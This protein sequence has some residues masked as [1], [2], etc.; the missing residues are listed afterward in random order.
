MK[1]PV[2]KIKVKDRIRKEQGNIEE[3]AKNIKENNLINP[4]VITPDNELIAGARRLKACKLLG[5]DEIEVKIMDITDYEDK[6]MIE[7]SENELRKDFTFSEKLEWAEKIERIERIKAE[8]R[9]KANLKQNQNTDVQNFARR[10][11]KKTREKV[12]EKV[13]LGSGE[14][15]RKAKY[16]AN[17]ADKELINKL[18]KEQISIHGAYQNLKEEKEKL[19]EENQSLK[20]AKESLENEIDE[21][22]KKEIEGLQEEL[23]KKEKLANNLQS[24]LASVSRSEMKISTQKINDRCKE[25]TTENSRALQEIKHLIG[26]KDINQSEVINILERWQI[27]LREIEDDIENIIT[28][29]S[30]EVVIDVK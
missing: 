16:I 4:I 5:W 15:Y 19:A 11:N 13:G 20:N 6:L 9:S 28:N 26:E 2:K 14:T 29:I 18:D 17:N 22:K 24:E 8:E 21:L 23:K 3:L 25:I 1:T 12:A 27:N 7:V 10:E 30:Q